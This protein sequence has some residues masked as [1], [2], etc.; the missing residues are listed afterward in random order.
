MQFFKKMKEQKVLF[1]Y[2]SS[3]MISIPVSLI[4]SYFVLKKID[5]VLMGTWGAVQIFQN[6]IAFTNLGI[7]NG[8]NRELPLSQGEGNTKRAE[9]IGSTVYGYAMVQSLF[10]LLVCIILII[11]FRKDYY[12]DFSIA[13]ICIMMVTG[14]FTQ[15]L[16]G[17]FRSSSDFANLS[18]IN[19][20]STTI[21]L[22]SS[23]IIILGFEFYLVYVIL[24]DII[25]LIMML[26][27]RPIKVKPKLQISILKQLIKTGLPL[28]I[29]SYTS[30]LIDTIPRVFVLWKAGDYG[31][32]LMA[33]V[34]MF[35]GIFQQFAGQISNYFNP[36]LTFQYGK[37]KDITKIY[38]KVKK[39]V[40]IVIFIVLLLLIPSYFLIY[41]YLA[42]FPKYA[43]SEKYIYLSFIVVPF[44]FYGFPYLTA[45]IEKKFGVLFLQNGVKAFLLIISLFIMM[46]F[47]LFNDVLTISIIS[48]GISY[49]ILT[50]LSFVIIKYFIL[51]IS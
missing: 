25:K 27:W 24:P 35:T 9:E 20:I 51:K 10:Y 31:L 30:G 44:L 37:E 49:I 5:P 47:N 6:Y 40:I 4:T 46:Q 23:P 48:T 17:T 50:M 11:Y 3:A 16:D 41:R 33:P 7:V 22:I 2:V 21:R 42:L 18:K 39:I 38:N 29:L 12:Y 19:W 45:V 8:M 28:Y 15:Y 13:T 43:E 26:K 34:F 14:S 32:G 36:R 1:N